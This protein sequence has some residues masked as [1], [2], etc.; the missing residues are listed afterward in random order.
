MN[1]KELIINELEEL[2]QYETIYYND[3]YKNALFL[4]CCEYIPKSNNNI[5]IHYDL[6]YWGSTAFNQI[7]NKY[8]LN[9]DWVDSCSVAVFQG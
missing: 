2:F 4:I 7:M 1:K 6:N 8:N 5:H 9:F 3:N